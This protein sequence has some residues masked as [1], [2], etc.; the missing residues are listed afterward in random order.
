M[1]KLIS[2]VAAGVLSTVAFS[3]SAQSCPDPSSTTASDVVSADAYDLRDGK[4]Y[5]ITGGG[6]ADMT[7]CGLAEAGFLPLEATIRLDITRAE[8]RQATIMAET[9]CSKTIL[10]VTAPDYAVMA[11]SDTG[12]APASLVVPRSSIGDDGTIMIFVGSEFEGESCGGTVTITAE[13]G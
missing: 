12:G 10:Y 6:T 4:S 2:L 5:P 1:T 9:D 8:G 13:R 3:A 11:V 7:D